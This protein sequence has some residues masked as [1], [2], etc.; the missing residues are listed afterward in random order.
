LEIGKTEIEEEFRS[1][2]KDATLE[3][4]LKLR[5]QSEFRPATDSNAEGKRVVQKFDPKFKN[6]T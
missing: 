4:S 6:P 2:N 5:Y 3:Y 1:Q